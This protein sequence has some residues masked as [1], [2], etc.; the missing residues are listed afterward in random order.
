MH[1]GTLREEDIEHVGDPIKQLPSLPCLAKLSPLLL[2]K[3]LEENNEA[4]EAAEES[5]SVSF[6]FSF[7]LRILSTWRSSLVP[8]PE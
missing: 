8:N 4:I 5:L 2:F 7:D 6:K 3:G 1:G